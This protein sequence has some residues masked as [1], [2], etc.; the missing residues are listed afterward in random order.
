MTAAINRTRHGWQAVHGSKWH[1]HSPEKAEQVASLV[2]LACDP[3]LTPPEA[4]RVLC[5]PPEVALALYG[6]PALPLLAL[7]DPL[8]PR[9][10]WASSLYTAILRWDFPVPEV[11]LRRLALSVDQMHEGGFE[12]DKLRAHIGL[13]WGLGPER[14]QEQAVRMGKGWR[15]WDDSQW[16]TRG[17]TLCRELEESN[18]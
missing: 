7:E 17:V 9:H 2:A 12:L 1:Y 3:G 16:Q 15:R 5:G 18:Q 14:F 4:A 10:C 11:E 6:N 8:W 13:Y